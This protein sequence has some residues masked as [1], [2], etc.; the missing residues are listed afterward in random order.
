[1]KER[2]I[3]SQ[4]ERKKEKHFFRERFEIENR[5]ANLCEIHVKKT[6]KKEEDDDEKTHIHFAFLMLSLAQQMPMTSIWLNR[7]CSA[8]YT[9]V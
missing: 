4:I 2:E 3:N 8:I 5:R 9:R 7:C 1:M 6:W